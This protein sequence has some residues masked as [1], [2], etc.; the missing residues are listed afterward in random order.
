MGE[1]SNDKDLPQELK[2]LK[3]RNYVFKIC[4]TEYN[5]NYGLQNY[6]ITKVY[7]SEEEINAKK[8]RKKRY[9]IHLTVHINPF[10]KITTTSKVNHN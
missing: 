6:T 5:S 3:G 9:N 4:L 1:E 8:K 10:I 2:K 7:L